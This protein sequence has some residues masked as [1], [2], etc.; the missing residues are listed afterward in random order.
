MAT[1]TSGDADK[2]YDIQITIHSAHALPVSDV[3]SLS[4]DPYILASLRVPEYREK[5]E[6]GP[7]PLLFRTKTIHR[8]R[9]PDWENEVWRVGGI[10]GSGF[11]LRIGVRDE[12]AGK[13]DDRLG[14]A[15]VSFFGT[16]PAKKRMGDDSDRDADLDWGRVREGLDMA[17]REAPIKKRRGGARAFLST[18]MTAAMAK[19]VS[20]K[21]AKV[22]VSVRVL[23]LSENQED[24]RVYTLGPNYYSL[25]F[26]PLLGKVMGTKSADAPSAKK[27][28]ISNFQ[29]NKLQLTGPVPKDLEHRYVGYRPFI[30]SLFSKSGIKGRI[31]NRALKK[32]H[33]YVY[34]H[35]QETV[36]GSVERHQRAA[37][38]D[39]DEKEAGDSKPRPPDQPETTGEPGSSQSTPQTGPRSEANPLAEQFLHMVQ[40]GSGHRLYTYVITLDAQWRFTETGDEFAIEMLSKHSVSSPRN[41]I[42]SALVHSSVALIFVSTFDQ[43]LGS[44]MHADAA[45]YIAYS[46]EMFVRRTSTK[47][48]EDDEEEETDARA[49]SGQE[50]SQNDGPRVKKHPPSA[51]ELV[52]DNDSG[53]YR[54]HKE[55]LPLLAEFLGR[56]VNL[57]AFLFTFDLTIPLIAKLQNYVVTGGPGGLGKITA[58]DGFDEGLKD[59]KKRRAEAKKSQS[60]GEQTRQMQ[61]RRGSS[62]SSVGSMS[63]GEVEQAVREGTQ[64]QGHG[65]GEDAGNA[66][67]G[68]ANGEEKAGGAEMNGVGRA[69]DDGKAK[70]AE[71]KEMM[72]ELKDGM[73]GITGK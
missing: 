54:P 26:S 71:G 3:P 24:R 60:G 52:I 22:V 65:E 51:Y 17:R 16:G 18:Y 23:G 5:D 69:M 4:A 55:L 20:P 15:R 40:H 63:S 9:D 45:R 1:S 67:Q 31:L 62:V 68:A 11:A 41:F 53:T 43:C 73:A 47:G 64:G 10:P 36:Y 21:S 66:A 56:E 39:T 12:D 19:G 70:V 59:T 8:T 32:Q 13:Q 6:P 7:P 33:R 44:Q 42:I 38:V 48:W 28:T 2:L 37:N 50:D 58:M 27:H 29:A 46:G 14:E 25:H 35:N 34:S 57:G 30:E 72:G 61:V 49:D